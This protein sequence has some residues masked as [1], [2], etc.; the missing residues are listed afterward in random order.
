M[1]EYLGATKATNS[2]CK[3]K[4]DERLTIVPTF[5]RQTKKLVGSKTTLLKLRS[6]YLKSGLQFPINDTIKLTVSI[7]IT[8]SI[9]G[10]L[11]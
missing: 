1:S 10:S 6:R 5:F 9:S 7:Q 11:D 8:I 3:G 2:I 4:L